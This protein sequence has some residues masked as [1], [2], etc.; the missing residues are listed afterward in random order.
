MEIMHLLCPTKPPPDGARI[1]RRAA[2]A[3]HRNALVLALAQQRVHRAHS[4]ALGVLRN[5]PGGR[6]VPYTVLQGVSLLRQQ[7]C[8]EHWVSGRLLVRLVCAATERL[9]QELLR[10]G[11]RVLAVRPGEELDA[12]PQRV[13]DHPVEKPTN[14]VETVG[15]PLLVQLLGW[16]RRWSWLSDGW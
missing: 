11:A 10:L 1:A 4:P 12:A 8:P 6:R 9:F 7:D 15:H 13:A 14:M 5:L 16:G 2:A 3:L